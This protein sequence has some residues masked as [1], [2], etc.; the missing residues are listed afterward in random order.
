MNQP[1]LDPQ[2]QKQAKIYARLSRRLMAIDLSLTALYTLA[3]LALGW[4]GSLK[5]AL[6]R[7]TSSEWLLVL[8]VPGV[9][10]AI[11][12]LIDL[13]LSY[14]SGFVLPHRKGWVVD[15]LKGMAI[16]IPL[17]A[18]LLEI[19]YAVLRAAPQTWWLWTGG[20]LLLFTVVLANLGPVLIAPLFNK[21]VPLGEEHAELATRLTRL[22]EGAGVKVQ[23]V[24]TFDISRRTKS[25]NAALT[26]L[27][28]TRRIILGDTLISE[29]TPDEI[30][31]VMAHELGHQVN[32]DIP[33]GIVLQTALTLG[34]LF[35]AHLGLQA[36]VAAFGYRGPSD[37]AAF[38]LL[39][40]VFGAY[41]LVTMPLGNAFS[42]WR[43]RRADLYALRT[44]HNGAALASAFT[45]L[46]NQNLADADPEPWV[47]FLLYSHPALSKRIAAAQKGSDS[48][49][50]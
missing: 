17:S 25:A 48:R 30:E 5:S 47:E 13:P 18:I 46:A 39:L 7:F 19:I 4:A 2:R 32:K 24:F 27:G 3:W 14:Y 6:Q 15:L 10:A 16:E 49:P 38:P 40:V 35:L 11:F 1:Q 23:G 9:F 22:A 50:T 31:T 26:G 29:F 34:G 33:L 43:E 44:T 41:G 45:R 36:G 28:G 37:I 12:F 20:I 42:R 21:Y 8:A